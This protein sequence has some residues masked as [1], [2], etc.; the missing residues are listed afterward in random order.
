MSVQKINSQYN[1]VAKTSE[2]LKIKYHKTEEMEIAGLT[3]PTGSKDYFGALVLPVK[4]KERLKYA[5]HTISEFK[6][7]MLKEVY[8]KLNPLITK[9]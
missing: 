5:E 7:K 6:D 1:A 8:E 3:K 4:S 9:N 2:R